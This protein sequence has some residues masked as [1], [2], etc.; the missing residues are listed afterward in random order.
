VTDGDLA[1]DEPDDNEPDD[2]PDLDAELRRLFADDRL[3]LPVARAAEHAVLAGAHRRRRHRMT[4]AAATGVLAVAA[5]VFV[6]AAL[7][8]IGG[9]LTGR[10]TA[11]A[12]SP[13]LSATLTTGPTPS[14]VD[15]ADVLGP[16]GGDG[17]KL[18][19][20]AAQVLKS[21]YGKDLVGTM[22]GVVGKCIGYTIDS[23]VA[24]GTPDT[25]FSRPTSEVLP[26][27]TD[28]PTPA[29]KPSDDDPTGV[30]KGLAD[31]RLLTVVVSPR[32]TIVELGGAT[33]LRTP[34]GIGL[35]TPEQRIYTAYANTARA[36]DRTVA[37][38]VPG[39]RA[40]SYVFYLGTDGTVISLWLRDGTKLDCD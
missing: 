19:M 30:A 1:H 9:H 29:S 38:P 2:R 23:E 25:I 18:G 17:L 37:T 6:G 3:T 35:G 20:P 4:A 13:R 8:G 12:A 31:T 26:S 22:P 21:G 16:Y 39:N 5:L 28:E 14:I 36:A 33:A 32:G 11:A 27:G 10:V 15:D 40:A 34:E 7:T 24:V